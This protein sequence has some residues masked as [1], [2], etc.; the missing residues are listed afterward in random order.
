MLADGSKVI[1]PRKIFFYKAQI[2]CF[3]LANKIDMLEESEI[4]AKKAQLDDFVAEKEFAGWFPTSAKEN[5][6]IDRAASEL[7]R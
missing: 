7:I 5:K 2:P 1:F 4:D 6:N 3:L